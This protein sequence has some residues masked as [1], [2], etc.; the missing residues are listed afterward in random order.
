MEECHGTRRVE[1]IARF[2]AQTNRGVTDQT[3]RLRGVMD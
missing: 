1:A 3:S 2:D